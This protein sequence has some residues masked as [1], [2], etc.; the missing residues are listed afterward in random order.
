METMLVVGVETVAGANLAVEFAETFRVTGL[1]SVPGV[2]LQGCDVQTIKS[3]DAGTVRSL[4]QQVRP[5]AVVFCGQAAQ[6][7]WDDEA[8]PAI[9]DSAAVV[10]ANAAAEFGCAFSMISSDGVF[11][12]PW[13]SHFEDD[14]EHYCPTPRA[15]QIRAIEESVFAAHPEAFVVR[16]HL[17]GLSPI[18]NRP[19]LAERLLSQLQSNAELPI[20]SLR[21]ASPILATDLAKML[22]VAF[23][24]EVSGLLHIAGGERTNP[25]LFAELLA[26]A[27][28]LPRPNYEWIEELTDSVV[29]FG[30]S[31]TTLNCSQARDLLELP[32]PLLVEGVNRLIAQTRNGHIAK[33]RGSET[34]LSK[35]A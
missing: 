4:L 11:T 33:L 6:S 35:A 3:H 22:R 27:A 20:D 31:E 15:Q 5:S 30:C 2:C 10:W 7:C 21:H 14:D 28:E 19:S 8:A 9:D 32:M 23:D 17:F 24:S 12:G 25:Y 26:E 13:L 18:A 16:T 1:S 29:G 34:S